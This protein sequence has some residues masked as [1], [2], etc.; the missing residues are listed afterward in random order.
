MIMQTV[1]LA[2]LKSRAFSFIFELPAN[3][4]TRTQLELLLRHSECFLT[5]SFIFIYFDLHGSA[6]TWFFLSVFFLYTTTVRIIF[7]L[8]FW[9]SHSVLSKYVCVCCVLLYTVIY[10]HTTHS[11]FRFVV[12]RFVSAL[13]KCSWPIDKKFEK[14]GDKNTPS[15]RKLS[16]ALADFV[17]IVQL[18]GRPSVLREQDN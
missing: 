10:T 6:L 1:Y 8:L 12:L 9:L 2:I 13:V 3:W 17:L 5:H 4:I 15:Q 7:A 11:H 14:L 18:C 16:R